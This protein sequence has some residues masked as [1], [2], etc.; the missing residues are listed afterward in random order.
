LGKVGTVIGS[1]CLYPI[2]Q[3]SSYGAVMGLCVVICAIG[4]Y[5]TYAFVDDE[6]LQETTQTTLLK[7]RIKTMKQM[8]LQ[9]NDIAQTSQA[10]PNSSQN[11]VVSD[12]AASRLWQLA[13]HWL[14]IHYFLVGLNFGY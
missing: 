14:Y 7:A 13:L 3:A 9:N 5:L 1:F 8:G 11:S 12:S 6:R 2:A 10:A 4:I